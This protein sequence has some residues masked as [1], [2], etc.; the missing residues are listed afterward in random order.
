MGLLSHR[1]ERSEIVE[2]DHIYTWRAVFAYSHHGIYVGGSK[3]VH[4][5]REPNPGA[6][7]VSFL[8]SSDPTSDPFSTISCSSSGVPSTC[9]DFPDCDF[10]KPGSG[11]VLSCLDCFLGRGSLYRYE[12]GVTPSA[13]LTKLRG[14]TCTTAE[15]DPQKAVIYRAMFLLHNG[16]GNYD[17]FKNNC[18]DFSIYCKTGLSILDKTALGRSGQAVCGI[19]F[20]LAAVLSSPV[21]L[22]MSGP[23]GMAAAM[24]GMYCMSRYASDMGVR[25]DTI[26]IPVEDMA[27]FFGWEGPNEEFP[28]ENDGPERL[29]SFAGNDNP[30]AKRQK[31]LLM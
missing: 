9:S 21:K 11:V 17:V 23:V 28:E 18:E 1:V 27:L 12:Y 2:G 22:F 31:C 14:G 8:S 26:K 7:G 24:A 30:P 29:N 16:F 4:F 5:T 13:F 25:T 20:P 10:R 19:S 3:V 15:S 6:S